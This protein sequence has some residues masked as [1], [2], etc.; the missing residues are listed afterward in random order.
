MAHMYDPTY[1]LLLHKWTLLEIFVNL[2]V[3][4]FERFKNNTPT[5][6]EIMVFERAQD[7]PRLLYENGDRLLIEED[8]P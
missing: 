8:L 7:I 2:L 5:I 4:S 3:L 1:S 6:A